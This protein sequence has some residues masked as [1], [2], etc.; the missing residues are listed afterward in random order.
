MSDE[1][2]EPKRRRKHTW[3]GA[4]PNSGPKPKPYKSVH[5]TLYLREI[6]NDAAHFLAVDRGLPIS[7]CVGELIMKAYRERVQRV[8]KG[9]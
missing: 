3:G 2:E 1:L 7:R 8:T 6:E 9:E 4:R 5:L